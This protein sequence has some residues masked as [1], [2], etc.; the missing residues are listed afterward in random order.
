[1][2]ETLRV[3]WLGEG[4]GVSQMWFSQG[5]DHRMTGVATEPHLYTDL[6]GAVLPICLPEAGIW[7]V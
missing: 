2:K 4:S 3:G 5:H 6:R 7:I 1:M